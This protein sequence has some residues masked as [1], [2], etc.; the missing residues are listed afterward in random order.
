MT[1]RTPLA[2]RSFGIADA[3][4]DPD[5]DESYRAKENREYLQWFRSGLGF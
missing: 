3:Y 2:A 1:T 4:C 5:E